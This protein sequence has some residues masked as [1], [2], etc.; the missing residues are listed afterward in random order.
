MIEIDTSPKLSADALV[1]R[2]R[3]SS[4]ELVDAVYSQVVRAFE[5]EETR[6]ATLEAK[7]AGM[8]GCVGLSLTLTTALGGAF[9]RWPEYLGLFGWWG[10]LPLAVLGIVLLLG[11][12]AVWS[13][14]KAL[15]VTGE[16]RAHSE[17][18][19]FNQEMLDADDVAKYQRFQTVA[20]WRLYQQHFR[21]HEAKAATIYAAQSKFRSFLLAVGLLGAFLV[22]GGGVN[23]WRTNT[24][25]SEKPAPVGVR[26]A[27]N[28]DN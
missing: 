21:L 24:V 8:P 15:K 27:S 23:V 3:I 17:A 1:E 14:L 25:T 22:I 7:A 26:L 2:M 12:S 4:T 11:L 20:I 9:V 13:A 19:I 5:H 6:Q 10:F 28:A 18:D 16:Y